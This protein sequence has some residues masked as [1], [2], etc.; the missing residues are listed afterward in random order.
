MP[1]RIRQRV[2]EGEVGERAGARDAAGAD[3]GAAGRG[4]SGGSWRKLALGI[5]LA[6]G[7]DAVL[8]DELSSNSMARVFRATET[9]KAELGV[10]AYGLSMPML[11][12]VFLS[13]V[14]ENLHS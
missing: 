14:G 8:L 7:L 4:Y 5:A 10:Q 1:D 2:A 9:A 13:V 11:E 12:Q 6:S 3:G